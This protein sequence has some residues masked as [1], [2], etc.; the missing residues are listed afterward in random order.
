MKYYPSGRKGKRM[1]NIYLLV[2]L[3]IATM[4]FLVTS[5]VFVLI[6]FTKV[7]KALKLFRLEAQSSDA[8]WQAVFETLNPVEQVFPIHASEQKIYE[9]SSNITVT[10][11][12]EEFASEVEITKE[13]ER[14]ILKQLRPYIEVIVDKD[15]RRMATNYYARV[16]IVSKENL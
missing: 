7:D 4:L 8:H 11:D 2:I 10:R 12:M 16:R 13:L 5:Y 9:L 1:D 15:I 6:R 3:L 14:D